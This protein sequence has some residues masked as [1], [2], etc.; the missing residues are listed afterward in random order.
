M[1]Q[2]TVALLAPLATSPSRSMN[3][4]SPR[5]ASP[6]VARRAASFGAASFGAALLG[7]TWLGAGLLSGGAALAASEAEELFRQGRALLVAGQLQ[8]ACAQLQASQRLEPRL[9]TQLNIAFCQERLGQ[10]ATAWQGFQQAAST[11]RA[12]RDGE[13]ERF[14]RE[15][16][17]ALAPRVPRLRLRL[18]EGT[19]EQPELTLDGAPL[20]PGA[21][22]LPL[23]PGEHVVSARRDGAEYWRTRLTLRESERAEV[24]VPAPSRPSAAPATP[25]SARAAPASP[26]VYELGAFL[27]FLYAASGGASSPYESPSQFEAVVRDEE[28]NPSSLSCAS[29]DCDYLPIDSAGVVAGVTGFAG[30]ALTPRLELGLRFVGGPRADGGWLLA[31]GPSATF[32]AGESLRVS[33]TILVGTASHSTEG[34][35][36]LR[37]P[38]GGELSSEGKV[39]ASIGFSL[40]VGA[41]LDLEISDSASGVFA[42]QATPLVLF[43]NA[44]T[45][46]AL[47]VGVAYRWE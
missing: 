8:Q 6:R 37:D 41:V 4:R 16:A 45:A 25:S 19:A 32:H 44:G 21:E 30:Y 23:D 46:L 12:Q 33:P 11:A 24:V 5:S 31:L 42:L 43:G 18:P 28:G 13:R 7:A 29:A 36:V 38:D 14:A 20:A 35:V 1:Q 47:P 2:Y 39:E 26:F 22:E 3:V 27:G 10:L 15:R 9:G 40:G 34:L 17:A